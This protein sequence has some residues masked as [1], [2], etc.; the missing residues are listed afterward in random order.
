MKDK[1][2]Y[3]KNIGYKAKKNIKTSLE[4][5]FNIHYS[6]NRIKYKKM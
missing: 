1:K 3:K 5:I 2:Y 4:R 6:K